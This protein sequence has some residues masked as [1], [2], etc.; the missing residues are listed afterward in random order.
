VL[1]LLQGLADALRSEMLLHNISIHIFM[2]AGIDS[3]GLVS[4][5][6]EKPNI[7]K[8]IEEGDK[9]ISPEECAGHLIRGESLVKSSPLSKHEVEVGKHM[10]R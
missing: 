5:N 1:I 6:A 9:I 7:T 3:P 2:P 4:E 8:K 10:A